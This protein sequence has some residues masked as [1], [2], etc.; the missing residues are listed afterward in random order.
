M[1]LRMISDHVTARRDLLRQRGR[2]RNVPP[3]QKECRPRSV[4]IEKFEQFRR[5]L[6]VRSVVERQRQR[7]WISRQ[8]DGSPEKLRRGRNGSPAKRARGRQRACRCND[9]NVLHECD[10][11]SHNPRPRE[12]QAESAGA[13]HFGS[14]LALVA[15]RRAPKSNLHLREKRTERGHVSP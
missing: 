2:C 4:R 1:R 14:R 12:T 6:R 9:R 11:F 3:D 8:A 13:R 10:G 15:L 5:D 7:S